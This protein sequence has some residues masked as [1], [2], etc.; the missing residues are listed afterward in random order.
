MA[1]LQVRYNHLTQR[2][3]TVRE[4]VAVMPIRQCLAPGLDDVVRRLKIRLADA[5]GDDVVPRA[6]AIRLRAPAL[7]RRLRNRRLSGVLGCSFGLA[8]RCSLPKT[9]SARADAYHFLAAGR[10]RSML[11]RR[12]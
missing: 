10:F 8:L 2:Q 9:V 12:G 3:N 1:S 11:P 6:A 4:R 7:G 5:Q